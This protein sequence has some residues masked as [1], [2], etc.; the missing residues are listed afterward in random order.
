ME[1]DG[2]VVCVSGVRR[3]PGSDPAET[4]EKDREGRGEDS[5]SFLS[6]HE[7]MGSG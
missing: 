1:G 5:V 3:I 4:R 6:V 7:D 2:G